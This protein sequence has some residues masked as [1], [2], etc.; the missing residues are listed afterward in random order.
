ML[1]FFF[2]SFSL[3][4]NLTNLI[5]ES[6]VFYSDRFCFLLHFPFFCFKLRHQLY[7]VSHNLVVEDFLVL[8]LLKS[9]FDVLNNLKITNPLGFLILRTIISQLVKNSFIMHTLFLDF[10]MQLVYFCSHMSS[11][12]IWQINCTEYVWSLIVIVD[13]RVLFMIFDCFS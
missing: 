11:L 10:C 7:V 3:P 6:G 1:Y 4:R 8:K 13:C 9:T 12:V 5:T 2:L